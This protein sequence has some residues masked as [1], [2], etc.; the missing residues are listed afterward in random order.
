MSTFEKPEI[1]E[2]QPVLPRPTSTVKR[3]NIY[4][5]NPNEEVTLKFLMCDIET[6]KKGFSQESDSVDYI[7]VH[8][9]IEYLTAIERINF[10]NDV[11]R[12]LKKG[13]KITIYSSHW[14]A[15]KTYGNI[16]EIQWPPVAE[17]W[18]PNLN[19]KQREDNKIT[20]TRYT[21]DY[22][23]TWGYGMHPLLVP[24]NPEYQQHALIFWK[25]APQDLIATLIKK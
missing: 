6:V 22:E 17:S 16:A 10:V 23:V 13:G 24:R 25:E 21:C 7:E 20:E 3:E 4:E 9:V 1:T 5:E 8:Y 19:K 14:A 18:Y 2:L 12:I 15:N 11:H